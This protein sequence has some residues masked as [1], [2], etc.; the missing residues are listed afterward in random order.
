[1][2]LLK[3]IYSIGELLAGAV[4]ISLAA[5]LVLPD[6][7]SNPQY[8][9]AGWLVGPLGGTIILRFGFSPGWALL[10]ATVGAIMAPA[11][12]AWLHGKNPVEVA[13]ELIKVRDKFR[14]KKSEDDD[15][16]PE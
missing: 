16:K 9:L 8:V 11:I 13:E 14:R 12:I 3:F 5:L 15:E 2:I 7:R 4:A 6:W 1:M 10:A